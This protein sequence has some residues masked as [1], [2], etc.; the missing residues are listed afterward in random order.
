MDRPS[1][2]PWFHKLYGSKICLM[3]CPFNVKSAFADAFKPTARDIRAAKDAEGLL[4]LIEART[5]MNYEAF[6]Y[7]TEGDPPIAPDAPDQCRPVPTVAGGRRP[8]EFDTGRAAVILSG[9]FA[10]D[11]DRTE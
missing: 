2:E 4:A 3:V 11:E 9:G 6:D 7:G 10:S 1:C 8:A 5:E